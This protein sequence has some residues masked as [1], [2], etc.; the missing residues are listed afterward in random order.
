[1]G[2]ERSAIGI[3]REQIMNDYVKIFNIDPVAASRPRVTRYASYYPKAYNYFR[4]S[5]KELV[6]A[7]NGTREARKGAV[8]I[9]IVFDMPMPKSWTKKKKF[10]LIG[11]PHTQKPDI[12][13][14][15]KAVLDGLNG[16]WFKDDSQVSGLYA[17][18]YW[19]EKGKI[20]V[21]MK[22]LHDR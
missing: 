11:M 15:T 12:D 14:L 6:C 17:A 3:E 2:V 9:T 22:D 18:K 10:E 19:K 4:K 16:V 7:L 20:T 13:N 5:F 21:I 8:S 1:M